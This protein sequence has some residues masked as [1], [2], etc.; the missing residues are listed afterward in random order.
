VSFDALHT[1]VHRMADLAD[2]R[3]EYARETLSETDVLSDPI[4]QFQRWM[5]QAI[6][7]KVPEPN[8]MALATSNDDDQ[9]SVRIVL[10]K[11]FDE[12]GFVFYTDT[13]SRK[14]ADLSVNPR[15]GLCLYWGELE[16]QIRIDGSARRVD[17]SDAA[18]YFRTRPRPSQLGA[19]T[20]HQSSVIASRE[21]LD[22][23]LAEASARFR[24]QDVPLPDYWGG[25]RVRPHE[26][27]FWQGR[28]S[29]LH[30]RVRYRRDGGVWVI[31]RLSP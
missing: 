7:A 14:G 25:Y 6:A 20:S 2:L 26:I 12:R 13:R 28:P 1:L 5:D 23:R 19:W 3:R 16:R 4:A 18:A 8:A 21:E 22:L 31:E 15:V 17:H 9:P 11:G 30:D 27:E 24:D 10:L 29:R